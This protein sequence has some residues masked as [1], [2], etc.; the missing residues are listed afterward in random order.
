MRRRNQIRIL[1]LLLAVFLIAAPAAFAAETDAASSE[2]I[3]ISGNVSQP[4]DPPHNGDPAE[5]GTSSAEVPADSSSVGDVVSNGSPADSSSEAESSSSAEPVGSSSSQ[6]ETP[7]PEGP[8]SSGTS[9]QLTKFWIYDSSTGEDLTSYFTM[10]GYTISGTVPNTV[11]SVTVQAESNGGSCDI[12]YN[13]QG[14]AEGENAKYALITL[15]G[16]NQSAYYYIN[17]TREMAQT[18]SDASS[19]QTGPTQSV[20]DWNTDGVSDVTAPSE[21]D[22]WQPTEDASSGELS[23][24]EDDASSQTSSAAVIE[25]TEE[26]GQWMLPVAVILII[27]GVLGVAFVVCDILYTKGILKKWI[28][29]HKNGE[30]DEASEESAE[31]GQ[32]GEEQTPPEPTETED[33]DEFFRDK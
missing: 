31:S 26:G 32:N 1:S 13:Q 7:P 4:E 19:G 29:P 14:L 20:V 6:G 11:A 28:I 33:W 30:E 3:N 24:E 9:L 22:S 2:S 15:T 5:S 17:V 8:S 10:D 21:L 16:E 18:E 27:L 23:A 25:G 12:K